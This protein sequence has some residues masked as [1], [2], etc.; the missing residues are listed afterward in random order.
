MKG[1]I[2]SCLITF[3]YISESV[4]FVGEIHASVFLSWHYFQWYFCYFMPYIDL[5]FTMLCCF[6]DS[7]LGILIPPRHEWNL[8][9]GHVLHRGWNLLR[10]G[11]FDGHLHRAK[12][13]FMN[14]ANQYFPP[15]ICWFPGWLL[16]A[17]KKSYPI[18]YISIF[19]TKHGEKETRTRQDIFYILLAEVPGASRWMLWESSELFYVYPILTLTL[20]Q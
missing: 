17:V 12:V 15:K 14:L 4:I 16:C 3:A 5:L 10:N 13:S 19:L 1:V 6:V 11:H 20:T 18:E 8:L 9:A 2:L 7:T